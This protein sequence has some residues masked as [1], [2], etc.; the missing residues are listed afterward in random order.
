MADIQKIH[1]IFKFSTNIPPLKMV[2][3]VNRLK[4]VKN[5]CYLESKNINCNIHI[6]KHTK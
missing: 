4:L 2:Q 6:P 1:K 3:F 5:C